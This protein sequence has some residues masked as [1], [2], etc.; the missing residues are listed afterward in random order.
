MSVVSVG[1]FSVRKTLIFLVSL[2]VVKWRDDIGSILI[3]ALAIVIAELV[4]GGLMPMALSISFLPVPFFVWILI[5]V[6]LVTVVFLGG[7]LRKSRAKGAPSFR[8]VPRK[9]M[10]PIETQ[11][12]TRFRVKWN[13]LIG[14]DGLADEIRF[15][16]EG[17][18]CP[19]CD[20][21]L[22][23]MTDYALLGWKKQYVWKCAVC[24]NSY[25]RPKEYLFREDRVAGRLAGRD[26]R[27]REEHPERVDKS[28]V[29]LKKV[30]ETLSSLAEVV[31][32]ESGKVPNLDVVFG[33]LSERLRVSQGRKTIPFRLSNEGSMNCRNAGFHLYFPK[34]IQVLR[35]RGYDEFIAQFGSFKG[36]HVVK[37]TYR[38]LEAGYHVR[39][40]ITVLMPPDL[41]G[42]TRIAC[43]MLGDNLERKDKDL[44]LEIIA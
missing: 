41:Y 33:D 8:T 23:S 16:V 39:I 35:G 37:I 21:E 3:A 31:A 9:P 15:Y 36:C 20:Y 17:P 10:L 40:P 30:E 5:P 43:T 22:D 7:R 34:G 28:D 29:R 14:R 19:Y 13:V 11:N 24:G 44:L 32:R 4:V 25:P 26:W 6:V 2:R 18:Y 1:L 38:S 12:V 27:K 42:E